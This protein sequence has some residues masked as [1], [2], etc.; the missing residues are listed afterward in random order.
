MILFLI[1]QFPGLLVGSVLGSFVTL[2]T[3]LVIDHRHERK[4]GW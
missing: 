4:E 3:I 2:A 1:D